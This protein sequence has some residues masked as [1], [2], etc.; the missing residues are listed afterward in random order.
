MKMINAIALAVVLGG[1]AMLATPAPASATY[2]SPVP[3][4][5]GGTGSGGTGGTGTTTGDS[6]G[7]TYCCRSNGAQCCFVNVGCQT[8]P[9]F[10]APLL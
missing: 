9:G 2:I 8:K 5:G 1:G 7:V 10:C 3:S 4:G 6:G